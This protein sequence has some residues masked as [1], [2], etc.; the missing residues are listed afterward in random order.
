VPR[1]SSRARWSVPAKP[2][3]DFVSVPAPSMR[4]A[5]PRRHVGAIASAVPAVVAHDEGELA[6]RRS[7]PSGPRSV[8]GSGVAGVKREAVGF[9]TTVVLWRTVPRMSSVGCARH[10]P[11]GKA[12]GG[13]IG[14]CAANAGRL[15][16]VKA[17]A[18]WAET[19]GMKG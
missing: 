18:H 1:A 7:K 13:T 19:T 4:V 6:E 5:V 9:A 12:R 10:N 17:P 2:N 8:P 14:F 15:N 11:F 16:L 3:S